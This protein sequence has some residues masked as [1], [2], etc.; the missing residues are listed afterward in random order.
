MK[1]VQSHQVTISH[2]K[3]LSTCRHDYYAND[4][5]R[6]HWNV[7]LYLIIIIGSYDS[8]GSITCRAVWW[9]KSNKDNANLS[10]LPVPHQFDSSNLPL[11]CACCSGA[12]RCSNSQQAKANSR[13]KAFSVREQKGSKRKHRESLHQSYRRNTESENFYRF[14]Q[15]TQQSH[16]TRSQQQ[17][18]WFIWR[19]HSSG[20]NG[21]FTMSQELSH[22]MNVTYPALSLPGGTLK[23]PKTR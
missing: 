14:H 15:Q 9:A 8:L 12:S 3:R 21:R 13:L 10:C 5:Q 23:P 11:G 2:Q 1:R 20:T 4:Q 16:S 17:H 22:E 19:P 7:C 18:V 6:I